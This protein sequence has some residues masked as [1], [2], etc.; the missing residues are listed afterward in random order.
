MSEHTNADIGN[1]AALEHVNITVPDQRLATLFYIAGLGFTRDPYLQV[2]DENMWAN[3]GA[4]Q[5]HLPTG[6]PQILRGHVGVV[7]PDLNALRQRLS[8][9]GK[10]LA[11]TRFSV[12]EDDG[13]II[14]TC[15]WGNRLR[16]YAPQPRFGA[17]RLGIPYVEFTIPRGT[18][19]GIAHFYE[20]IFGAKAQLSPDKSCAVL[21]AGRDQNLLY[22]ETAA[23]IPAYDGHHLAI[24]VADFSGPRAF[25]KQHDLI[26]EES[27]AY[28]YRFRDIFDLESGAKLFEI[29][30]EVRSLRHPMAGRPLVNRN[31]E[32]SQRNYERGRDAFWG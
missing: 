10:K 14:V 6:E 26:T 28:Q 22:R 17:M 2:G 24:Y 8:A 21:P 19:A 4:Q 32:Q 23:P 13:S 16:C 18:A 1:I 9:V 3:V 7:V 5:F 15:P 29:E 27:N 11:G 30:H 12:T 20:Q 31:P 25:L